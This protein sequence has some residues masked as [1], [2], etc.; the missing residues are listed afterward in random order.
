LVVDH[1][2]PVV[3]PL[4]IAGMDKLLALFDDL[5]EALRRI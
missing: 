3:R 1:V 4:E 5:A 2:R